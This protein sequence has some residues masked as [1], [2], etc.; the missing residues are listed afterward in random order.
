MNLDIVLEITTSNG[1]TFQHYIED[2]E[3]MWRSEIMGNTSNQLEEILSSRAS[4]EAAVRG[5]FDGEF[6]YNIRFENWSGSDQEA[7][8]HILS[9]MEAA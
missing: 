4:L 2:E 5:Y 1:E 6:T 9:N 3:L 8:T 7:W